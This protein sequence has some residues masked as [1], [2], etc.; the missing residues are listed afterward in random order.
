MNVN[1]AFGHFHRT[2]QAIVNNND[3]SKALGW[4][5][6]CLCDLFP[7]YARLNRW[8]LGYGFAIRTSDEGHFKFE[9]RKIE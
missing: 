8:N 1:V 5:I 6:G 7:E 3:G 4:S 2:D 9:N